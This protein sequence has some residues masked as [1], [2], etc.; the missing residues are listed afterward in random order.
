[1]KTH[2]ISLPHAQEILRPRMPDIVRAAAD[3]VKTW[4]EGF[5]PFHAM[6][7]TSR[8]RASSISDMFYWNVNLYLSGKPGVDYDEPQGQRMLTFDGWVGLRFKLVDQL[9]QTRN[10]PTEHALALVRQLPLEGLPGVRLHLGYRLDLTGMSLK[11]LFVTLP[12]GK[13]G[14][15]ND[16]VW[17]VWGEPIQASGTVVQ[18]PLA[19]LRQ[20]VVVYAY[21]DYS[22]GTK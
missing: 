10:Y 6:L 7:N 9:L 8:S 2:A 18:H 14:D 4:R 3:A 13:D 21:D 1:M 20:A 11:D 16:W 19:G 22:T 17:Q 15:F 12:N 5:R